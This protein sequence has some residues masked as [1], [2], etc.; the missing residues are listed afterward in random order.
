MSAQFSATDPRVSAWVSANAGAGKTYLLTD[1]VTRLLLSGAKPSRIL[2]LTYTKAAAAEMQTRLFNRLGEWALLPDRQLTERLLEI[3]A[4]QPGAHDLRKARR[5]FAQALEEPG[6]LKIQTIH[7]FCQHVLARFPVEAGIPARFSVLDERGSGELMGQA[8]TAVLER[9]GKGDCVLAKAVAVLA[10]RAADGR[11]AEILNFAIGDS[12]KLRA[13]LAAHDGDETRFFAHLR[14]TLDVAHGVDESQL[15][16]RFCEE[17]G[18]E[19]K[20]CERLAQWLLQGSATEKKLGEQLAAFVAAGFASEHFDRL[21]SVFFTDANEARKTL[22]TKA[23]AASDPTLT[24][25]FEQLQTRVLALEERRKAVANAVLTEAVVTVAF[26]VLAEFDRL[27][28]ERAALDYDDL[29]LATLNLLERRD[30]ASW[31]LYKLDGGLD[32]VLVDEAQD[33]SPEQ[34]KIVSKLTEDFFSGYGTRAD[35]PVRTVFAVGD[36]KQS[37]FSFQGAEPAQFDRHRQI[38]RTRAEGADLPFAD[39][40]PAVSRRSARAVLEFVDAVFASDAAR[41]GL[42]SSTAS[43]HHDPHRADIGR[44]EVWP[45]V[46][47]PQNQDSDPWN[48]PVD[49]PSRSSAQVMLASRI[50]T[51]IARWIR[52]GEKLPGT[53]VPIKAGDIMI[54]VRRRNAFAEEMIRQLLDKG[55][56]VAGADRMILLEQIAIADLVALGRFALLPDDDLNLAAL[57]KSPLLGFSDD[58][59]FALAQ[60]RAA[61]TLWEELRTRAAERPDFE[62]AHAYLAEALARADFHPSFEF[63]SELLGKGARERLVARMGGEAADAIDEFLALALAHEGA[64]PPSLESFLDWFEKGAGDVKRDMEQAGGAV[65][66]MTVHG[67]KGLEANVVI[68]P[69]TAQIP[70]H[71]RRGP[72]LYTDDCV[73]FG[74][75]K[76]FEPPPVTAAKSSAQDREMREYRRLLYVAATRAR[77]FLVVCGYETRN[78]TK[79][80]SWY[81]HLE[82]AARR[83]GHEETIA[84]ETVIAVGAALGGMSAPAER[85]LAFPPAVPAFL[86]RPAPPEPAPRVLRPSE[87]AGVEEPSLLS[88]FGD[89]ETRFR[90]GLLVH[91]LLAA[92]PHLPA[93]EREA[94]ARFYLKRQGI[95]G[96]DAASLVAET[97]AIL[98]DAVFAPLFAP[99]SRAE[100]ALTAV[101]PE[102]GNARINGQIDRLAVTED[103]VLIA[104]FKTNRPPPASPEKVPR[105]YRT[106]M[107]LYRAG[108]QKIYPGKRIDCALVWTDG[109]KL[110]PLPHELLDAE[111][112][113]IAAG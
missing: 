103:A 105:I 8:R 71:E 32:H 53:D 70:D 95:A 23:T 76:A 17:L 58:D 52:E 49:A 66:V 47:A 98:D 73:Y 24:A 29:T 50:A 72:L 67:A 87:A 27:K 102:L 85:V 79:T 6:G 99:N 91:A 111:I 84:G 88:P 42:T 13:L 110:M 75:A 3:G 74:V 34:W 100:V 106:Q 10:T 82:A 38:F 21:R 11:F 46:K 90:R 35:G 39:L 30:A 22:L 81:P 14:R 54:L 26:A 57:L 109:A 7:S 55:V 18:G 101:L 93:G 86:R 20:T 60:P 41:D 112:A 65:R 15:L 1:R 96:D 83:I 28:R 89:S 2:C 31:V 16:T 80:N 92:L 12:G 69:D 59:L 25:Q 44:V 108:L 113:A 9:A 45:T 33:T 56:P 51:R 77:E 61:R 68:L 107:A 37:I 48:L 64:H 94:A 36:E 19:R 78:G 40:R 104:D 5:L 63:F 43:I 97:F 4:Q 62:R